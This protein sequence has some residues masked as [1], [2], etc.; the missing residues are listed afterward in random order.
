MSETGSEKVDK[1]ERAAYH[2]SELFVEMSGTDAWKQFEQ[3]LTVEEEKQRAALIG[4][5]ML[6]KTGRPLPDA[7]PIDQRDVDFARGVLEGM[8]RPF[9]IM[10]TARLV[11]AKRT[12]DEPAEPETDEPGAWS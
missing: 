10:Q 7:P 2:I 5:L 4:L 8:S 1:T 12:K 9:Q 3:L 11:I 6:D